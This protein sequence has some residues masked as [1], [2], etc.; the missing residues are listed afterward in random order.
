VAAPRDQ[1]SERGPVHC[2]AFAHSACDDRLCAQGQLDALRSKPATV[3]GE[4]LCECEIISH[5]G[6][7]FLRK[8][9]HSL[10]PSVSI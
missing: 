9:R 1:R 7:V 3:L 5:P 4:S 8:R 6:Q 10:P 2:I